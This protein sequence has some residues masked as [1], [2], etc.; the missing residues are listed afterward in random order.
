MPVAIQKDKAVLS[1]DI[2]ILTIKS[3]TPNF[4]AINIP[5]PTVTTQMGHW[6]KVATGKARNESKVVR[7]VAIFIMRKY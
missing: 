7:N 4:L 6:A 3:S 5:P 1:A 2:Q